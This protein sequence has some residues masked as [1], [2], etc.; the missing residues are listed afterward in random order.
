MPK[1]PL[2]FKTTVQSSCAISETWKISENGVQAPIHCA[3]PLE[4]KGPGNAYTPEGLLGASLLSCIIGAFKLHCEKSQV[5]FGLL[6]GDTIIVMD[7][8]TTNGLSITSIDIH[9][10]IEQASDPEKVKKIL[11]T[12]IKDCPVSKCLKTGKTFHI[13]V[14]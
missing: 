12:T 11:E 9:F 1:F 4:F 10:Q 13:I 2:Q 6:S 8:D 3:L 7:K 5:S 14:R